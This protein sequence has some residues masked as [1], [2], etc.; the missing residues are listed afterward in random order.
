MDRVRCGQVRPSAK[1]ALAKFWTAVPWLL[2][3]D[4]MLQVVLHKFP[5]AG[6]I[7]GLLVFNAE[8]ACLQKSACGPVIL[9]R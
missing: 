7:G 4:I 5:E 6:V 8:L 9:K 1:N 3:A 2:K